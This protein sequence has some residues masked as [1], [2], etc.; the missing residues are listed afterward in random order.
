MPIIRPPSLPTK[1]CAKEPWMPQVWKKFG[2]RRKTTSIFFPMG[3]S[4]TSARS[5]ASSSERAGSMVKVDAVKLSSMGQLHALPPAKLAAQ[6][7]GLDIARLL[8]EFFA[9]TQILFAGIADW[10]DLDRPK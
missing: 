5:P 6:A 2:S 8:S 7:G 9:A 3:M 1:T 10:D 4:R